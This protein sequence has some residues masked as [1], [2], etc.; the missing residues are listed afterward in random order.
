MIL[1]SG[2]Y[3]RLD[4]GRV[5][6][7]RNL[8][9]GSTRVEDAPA[10]VLRVAPLQ[11]GL[12]QELS[13]LGEVTGQ[14]AAWQESVR[15]LSSAETA[16]ADALRKD[17]SPPSGPTRWKASSW[18]AALYRHDLGGVLATT[19]AGKTLQALVLICHAVEQS[20]AEAPFLVV[21][22]ASVVSNWAH[23]A[24][25]FAPES[26]GHSIVQTGAR[27]TETLE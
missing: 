15:A 19:W 2:R 11:A 20:R 7:L 26:P 23:E 21:A 16:S 18:L 6:Q 9:G 3:F 5:R 22:P 24:S 10:G 12:W 27:R 25:R 1:P 14:A 13:E 8:I 4:Q 17:W